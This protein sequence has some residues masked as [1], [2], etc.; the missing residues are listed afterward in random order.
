M[1]P[2]DNS[3]WMTQTP[4]LTPFCAA[5]TETYGPPSWSR[6]TFLVGTSLRL[7]Q[8][9]A[10]TSQPQPKHMQLSLG[11]GRRAGWQLARSTA[12]PDLLAGQAGVLSPA[13]VKAGNSQMP[14]LN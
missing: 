12:C 3:C 2:R 9:H 7:P 11:G 4:V 1:L 6:H 5:N 14:P 13:H 8:Q 10:L